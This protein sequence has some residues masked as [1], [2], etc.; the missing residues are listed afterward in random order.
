MKRMTEFLRLCHL[1]SETESRILTLPSWQLK[2]K[3]SLRF[4]AQKGD[5]WARGAMHYQQHHTHDAVPF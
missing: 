2:D 4:A 5:R 1:K 3:A